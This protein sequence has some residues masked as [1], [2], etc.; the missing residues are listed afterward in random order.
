MLKYIFLTI[1]LS[2][3]FFSTL[4][5]QNLIKNADCEL[6]IVNGKIPY[7]TEVDGTTWRPNGTDMPPQ[8]GQFYFFP[9]T[10]TRIA[11]LMQEIDVSSYACPIDLGRQT[12]SFVGYVRCF[13]QFPADIAHVYIEYLNLNGNILTDYGSGLQSPTSSWRRLADSRVAPVGTRRI[14]IRLVSTRLN[15]SDNDGSYDNLSLIP[16]PA[17]LKIDTIVKTVASCNLAN[18]TARIS[19]SGGVPPIRFKMDTQAVTTDSNFQNLTGG[20]HFIIATDA[21]NCIASMS[22][23]VPNVTGVSFI[24]Y[25]S[26]PSVCNR[27]NGSL[28]VVAQTGTGNLTYQ[29]GNLPIR[30]QSKFDSLASG[31]YFLT[32]RD[33]VGCT[34]TS[35]LIVPEKSRPVIDSVRIIPANCNKN[36][37]Q[38]SIF[39]RAE[40]PN[41]QYSLDSIS[42]VATSVFE[43]L[44]DNSFTVFVRDTNKCAVSKNITVA[45]LAPPKFDTVVIKPNTCAKDNGNISVT[46][47]NVTFSI[48]ST[49]FGTT[50]QFPNLRGGTYTIYIRDTGNCVVS[51]KAFVPKYLPPNIDDIKLIPE[52]CKKNDGQIIVKASSTAGQL[53]YSLDSNFVRRDSFLNLPSGIFTISVRDSFS[54]L[55]KQ[56]A[57]V[58]NQAT[59]IV[60][61]IKTAPSVCDGVPTGVVLV[62]AKTGRELF[63]S[64]D[65]IK[66]QTDYLFRNVKPGKYNVIVKD[67]NDCQT[68][69]AAEVARDCGLFIPTAFSPNEDGNNDYFIFFGDVAKIDKVLDFKVFNRWGNLLFSDNTVQMNNISNGWDGKF[70][71]S[72]VQAG[73]YVFYLKVQLKD[74]TAIEEKGDVTLLR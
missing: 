44:K 54:C 29:L 26:T 32:V 43:N 70:R 49:T 24:G 6:P 1:G 27:N 66:F 55:V 5:A 25:Q 30:S 74:G 71:G 19:V 38:V 8:S 21:M 16:S 15:G 47:H 62:K 51:Q 14:R 72:D 41:I 73:T 9:G 12:F 61:E 45:R 3:T 58:Q 18:G 40:T 31:R 52:S 63:Y 22:F 60:E 23:E 37:G 33:S 56:N 2:I 35:T 48:D 64:L 10:S 11:E 39:G 4:F 42:F 59:P 57:T 67:K 68:S 50:N 17:L 53:W 28:T 20:N 36:N 46:A 65:G 69:I 34:D 13:D 7:W